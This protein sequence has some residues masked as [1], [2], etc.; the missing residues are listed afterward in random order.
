MTAKAAEPNETRHHPKPAALA[1]VVSV[2]FFALL[3]SGLIKCPFNALFHFPCPA[4]GSSRAA[5]ALLDLDI[6]EALRTNPLAPFAIV[7]MLATAARVVFV[8][9]RD[10]SLKKLGE[11]RIGEVLVYSLSRL[12]LLSV[13]LWALRAIGLFGGL[14]DQ[15]V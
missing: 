12:A 9:Y 3:G 13:A 11:G 15:N 8:A 5:H 7:L 14:V 1:L 6:H 4:C 2:A 10:G